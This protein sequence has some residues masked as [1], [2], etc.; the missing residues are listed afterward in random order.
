M[1]I[2]TVSICREAFRDTIKVVVGDEEEEYVL[3]TALLVHHSRFFRNALT[4]HW[5]ESERKEVRLPDVE[6]WEFTLFA[7]WLVTGKIDEVDVVSG[8][9]DEIEEDAWRHMEARVDHLTRFDGR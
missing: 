7:Q 6:P 3:H 1:S 5:V 4:G 8:N 2:L 9:G